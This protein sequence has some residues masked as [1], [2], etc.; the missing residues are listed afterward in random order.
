MK[1]Y[2]INASKLSGSAYI[3]SSKSQSIRAILFAT[4]AKGTS[5]VENYLPSPDIVAMISA[6]RQLGAEIEQHDEALMITGVNGCPKTPDDVIDAGNSGLVLRFIACIA[7]LQDQYIVITGDHSIRH[8]RPVKPLIEALP[9]MG[10]LCESLTGNGYAPLILKGPFKGEQTTLSGEDSQPVSGLLIALAF[11][12]GT[13]TIKVRH[14]G[15]KPWVGLTLKW[16]DRFAIPYKNNDFVEYQITGKTEISAFSYRVPGDLSSLAFPLVA[17]LL[18][19][20]EIIIHDV[21]MSEPQGDKA[22]VEVLKKMGAR[23]SVNEQEKTLHVHQTEELHGIDVNIND[24]I[25]CV[26]ILAVVGCFATGTTKI[27]GAEI[28]R[29]KESDRIAA[30]TAELRKMGANIEELPDGLIVQNSQLH[31]ATLDSHHDHRIVMSLAVAAFATEGDTV[32][33]DVEC[34]DKSFPNFA[35]TMQQL[36]GKVRI[37]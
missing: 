8:N 14:P 7:G 5:T 20:S 6:C 36:G 17:A 28:A 15:E 12:Q 10:V 16:L 4:M 31:A 22:I 32:I 23:I 24:F 35:K 25:D 21:D 34:V 11:K 2:R 9:K 18:T 30:I 1:T 27:T 33:G 26:T 37:V 19:H 13:T 29:A 3:P